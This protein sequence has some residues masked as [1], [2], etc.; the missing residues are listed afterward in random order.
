MSEENQVLARRYFLE[1]MNQ[2]NW[3]T[4]HEILA[5]EFVF[6]LPTHPEPYRTP[7][8]FKQLVTMLH[9]AFPDFYIDIRD[10]LSQGDTVVTRWYGGGTH[11]G[12]AL[13]TVEGDIPASGRH[14]D[15]D[16]M[17]WHTI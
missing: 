5:P 14:F 7:D 9:S 1:I 4:L 13:H 2:A 10:M 12:G 15:I 16:G 8:G 6:T 17:T 11:L 3:D